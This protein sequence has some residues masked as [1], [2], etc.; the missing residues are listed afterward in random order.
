[1]KLMVVHL[2]RCD[3]L[4]PDVALSV[5]QLNPMLSRHAAGPGSSPSGLGSTRLGELPGLR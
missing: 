2:Q 5:G 4:G 3:F 1:M